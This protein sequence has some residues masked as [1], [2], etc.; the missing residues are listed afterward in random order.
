[1]AYIE[2]IEKILKEKNDF[3]GLSDHE[4]TI[5]L[6]LL[7]HGPI[8]VS[9]IGD[10]TG[11]PKV[12]IYQ[13]LSRLEKKGFIITEPT[14]RGARYD[15]V[16]PKKVIAHLRLELEKNHDK[17]HRILEYISSII[18]EIKFNKDKRKEID[19]KQ[20]ESVWLINSEAQINRHIIDLLKSAKK[21]MIILLPI[22]EESKTKEILTILQ[23][24]MEITQGE[25][26]LI[27]SWEIG[28]E[29]KI[30]DSKIPENLKKSGASI[31]E[32]GLIEVPF[33][34][35]F[36]DHQEGIVVLKSG[37]ETIPSFNLALWIRHPAY[38]ITFE[39]LIRKLND[40]IALRKVT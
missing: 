39:N 3:F 8:R 7:E 27:L 22:I 25:M 11:I 19:V 13:V 35:Y 31:Y 28:E 33:Q 6:T 26:N 5:Y 20:S 18:S 30:Q 32:W 9:E 17:D 29:T 23:E 36:T 24:Q 16:H 12:S 37:W 2:D 14:P 38:V 15:G 21:S 10:I 34:A 1:M 40:I 4:R